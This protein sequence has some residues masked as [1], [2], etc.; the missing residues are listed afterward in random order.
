MQQRYNSGWS[1]IYCSGNTFQASIVSFPSLHS[2]TGSSWVLPLYKQ[3][4][5]LCCSWKLPV[6]C[7]EP[8]NISDPLKTL[9]WKSSSKSPIYSSVLTQNDNRPCIYL[10]RV[11]WVCAV[12]S[13]AVLGINGHF[14]LS[15]TTRV[16]EIFASA[17][18]PKRDGQKLHSEHRAFPVHQELRESV[19]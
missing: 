13:S 10:R 9:L 11:G 7:S 17:P 18:S 14:S 4:M 2:I 3:L 12:S 5:T 19:P 8:Q 6:V 1:M 16:R 15:S